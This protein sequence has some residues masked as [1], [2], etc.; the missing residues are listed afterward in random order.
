MSYFGR[1][2]RVHLMFR[3]EASFRGAGGAVAP[4]K[5]KE[6]RKKERKKEKREK[7]EKKREKERRES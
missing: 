6:K 3:P 2:V 7:K 4:P 5:E 1:L